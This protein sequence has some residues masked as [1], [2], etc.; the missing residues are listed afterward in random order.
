[1]QNFLIKLANVKN[2][3]ELMW[4]REKKKKEKTRVTA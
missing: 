4:I 1:M 3:Q 2:K